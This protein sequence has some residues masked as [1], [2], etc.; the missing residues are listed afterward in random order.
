MIVTAGE[1]AVPAERLK[2]VESIKAEARLA[3]QEASIRPATPRLVL[4]ADA[5]E[6]GIRKFVEAAILQ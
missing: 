2:E 6:Q 3:I 5:N 4:I 1:S